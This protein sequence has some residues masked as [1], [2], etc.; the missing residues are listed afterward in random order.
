MLKPAS[1]KPLVLVVEDEAILLE[2]V[3]ADLRELGFDVLSARSGAQAIRL[4]DSDDR[5]VLMMTDITLPDVDGW[6]LAEEAVAR[7]P[8]LA[9]VY[10]SGDLDEFDGRAPLSACLSKPYRIA[11]VLAAFAALGVSSASGPFT[12]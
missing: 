7:R 2:T 11:S 4:L 6:R 12:S 8:S 10:A 9:V 3:S 5:I 1:Q